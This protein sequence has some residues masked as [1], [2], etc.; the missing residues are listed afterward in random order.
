MSA[1][2]SFIKKVALK[3]PPPLDKQF[4][5][6]A[7]AN[8]LYQ[9]AVRQAPQAEPVII[10]LERE[11][12]LV[13]RYETN[14]LPGASAE[15]LEY[16]ERLVKF[17]L[18]ARGGWRL[19]VSGPKEIG[20]HIKHSY[21]ATGSRRFDVG[22]MSDA[23]QK[24]LEVHS[25][26]AEEVPESNESALKIGGHLEGCRIGFDLGASDYK[27]AAVIEGEAVYS[28]EFEW[29]PKDQSDPAYH[30][31]H[32][33]SGL[34]QAAS[35]LPRV[36]AIGGSSAGIV[37]DNCIM[38]ASLFRS[39]ARERFEREVKPMF[40][41]LKAEWQVPLEIA[42]DGDVTALAG[43]LSFKETGV[44]GIAM[45]SSEAGGFLDSR[46][47]ITGW[48]N[49]LAFAPVDY[50]QEAAVD[51]WSQDRGVGAMY[52][53]QQAVNKL[54][55]EAGL[56]LPDEMSQPERLA[57]VQKLIS[58]GD[59]KAQAIFETI[60]VYLGYGVRHYADFYDLKNLLV[61]GRVMSGEGGAIIMAKAK[62]VLEKEFP[63][64]LDAVKLRLPDEKSKRVGQAIAAASLPEIGRS[65]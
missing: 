30:Y 25:V 36:D 10:A 14:V 60:G 63:E 57:Q 51:E 23:Y 59:K 62:E 28:R 46:G 58:R 53:S 22:L 44:L 18:W 3:V 38:V 31:Q 9:T 54:I 4:C 26:S 11:K 27:V 16:V 19:F 15:T 1:A 7:L 50:N 12:S 49:E 33:Q 6:P 13:S 32:I 65:G 42:N 43:A 20:D 17:L 64:L 55:P 45:G 56:S 37:I 8:R 39:I 35:H 5:P 21:C 52:F 61:L 34:K 40:R 41:R 24:P 48:L 29:N 2:S 47:A